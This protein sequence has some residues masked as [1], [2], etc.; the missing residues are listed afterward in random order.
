MFTD[1]PEECAFSIFRIGYQTI[2]SFIPGSRN[3]ENRELNSK[4]VRFEVFSAV[5]MKNVVSWDV[6]PCGS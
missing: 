2:R 6:T 5:T 1:V 4:Y 3:V